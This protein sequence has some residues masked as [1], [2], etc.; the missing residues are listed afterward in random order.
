M[1]QRVQV[2]LVCDVHEDETAG[3]Q[4]I[5][6]GLDGA[7]YEIDVCDQHANELRDAVGRYVGLGRRTAARGG[8]QAR[9]GGSRRR[10][11]RGSGEAAAIRDWARSQGLPVPERGRIPADLAEKYAAAHA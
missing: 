1:A 11:I 2:I 7:S 6:F 5:N 3:T 8:G 9:G 4:T 10:R